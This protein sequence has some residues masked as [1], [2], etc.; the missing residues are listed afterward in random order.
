MSISIDW[1]LFLQRRF[2]D[3]IKKGAHLREAAYRSLLHSGHVVVMSGMTLVVVFLGFLTMPA[4]TVQMDGACCAVGV[5]VAMIIALTNTGAL[6]F[7]FPNFVTDFDP[8]C[9]KK[10]TVES[11]QAEAEEYATTLA[12]NSN[13]TPLITT[14]DDDSEENGHNGHHHLNGGA[15]GVN[16]NKQGVHV[17]YS[18]PRFRFTRWVTKFPNNII[19]IVCLYIL[20]IPLGYQVKDM[21]I[22]QDV[23]VSMPR[24]KSINYFFFF[25]I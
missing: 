16:K 1:S 17:M 20:V 4:A 11:L 7:C 25:F 21:V 15:N 12:V 22:N 6:W 24:G 14:N 19:A 3:E 2:R 9:C 18:G 10:R 5:L 23:L 13:S 8:K